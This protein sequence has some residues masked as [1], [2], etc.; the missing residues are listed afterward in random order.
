MEANIEDLHQSVFVV[1][2]DYHKQEKEAGREFY[3]LTEVFDDFQAYMSFTDLYEEKKLDRGRSVIVINLFRKTSALNKNFLVRL[4]IHN[5][6]LFACGLC[7]DNPLEEYRSVFDC[8]YSPDFKERFIYYYKVGGVYA[9][10]FNEKP[11]FQENLYSFLNEYWPKL[12]QLSIVTSDWFVTKQEFEEY[13]KEVVYRNSEYHY[14]LSNIHL[15]SLE[16][17]MFKGIRSVSIQEI[18]DNTRWIILTGENGFGK[19]SLL[20]AVASGLYESPTNKTLSSLRVI[21]KRDLLDKKTLRLIGTNFPAQIPIHGYLATYGSSRLQISARTT[22]DDLEKQSPPTYS[23]FNT[24]AVLLDVEQLLKETKA[25]RPADFEQIVNIFKTLL[26]NLAKIEIDSTTKTI[27]VKYY[28]KDDEGNLVNE[29]V[30][31]TQLAAGYRNIIAMIGDMIYRLST[32]QDVSNLS[33]LEGIVIIDELELHLHPK[34]QKLF[35]QKLTELF[36]KIQ[37]I[38]STHS[39]IPLLGAPPET[40]IL[41][42]T[43]SEERGIE[44]E[45]L[46]VDFRVLTPNAILTSPIFGFQDLIPESKPHSEMIRNEQTYT[47]VLFNDQLDKQIDEYLTEE[48]K[49]ELLSL[50][51]K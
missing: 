44:V 45:K 24:D 3:F 11:S 28:E 34:Y 42:V 27:Q 51:K 18:P 36:P 46:D 21:Y 25:Y 13:R 1:L 5:E 4:I 12:S 38:A 50:L 35:V 48:N 7:N 19:T 15:S 20:Q 23:L 22:K 40:I 47:E 10:Q 43:R 39:P 33:D 32:K 29:G 16:I 41:H 6:L 2:M 49:Q 30:T 17:N 37:F 14:R 9:L 26:P 31:F 8:I